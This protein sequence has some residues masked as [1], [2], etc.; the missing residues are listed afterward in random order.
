MRIS[1]KFLYF[2]LVMLLFIFL[3]GCKEQ[4]TGNISF[5]GESTNENGE[6]IT[7]I[8]ITNDNDDD[9]FVC[10]N[11]KN[12]GGWKE[13]CRV[14]LFYNFYEYESTKAEEKIIVRKDGKTKTCFVKK[15][16]KLISIQKI[17]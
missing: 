6:I 10:F 5:V 3:F 17:G 4:G 2:L 11:G 8:A 15:W 1:Q 14:K 13:G 7:V 16:H 12:E 9:L